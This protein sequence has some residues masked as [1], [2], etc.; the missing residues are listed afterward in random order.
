M[1]KS[2]VIDENLERCL[3]ARRKIER[4]YNTFEKFTAYLEGLE[5]VRVEEERAAKQ[6]APG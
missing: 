2:K 3:R 1:K 4:K 5:Q 6:N